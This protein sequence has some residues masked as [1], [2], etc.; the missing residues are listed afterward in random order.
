[1]QHEQSNDTMHAAALRLIN[2]IFSPSGAIV[3]LNHVHVNMDRGY[4]VFKLLSFFLAAG[5]TT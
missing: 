1:M 5:A 3:N 2:E 4:W